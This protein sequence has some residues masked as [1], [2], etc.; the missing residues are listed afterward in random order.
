MTGARNLTPAP[1][2]LFYLTAG[3]LLGE[4]NGRG[5]IEV[6]CHEAN[7]NKKELAA[8]IL[9]SAFRGLEERGVVSLEIANKGFLFFKTTR[10][11]VEPLKREGASGLEGGILDALHSLADEGRDTE[12]E[13]VIYRWF[14]DGRHDPWQD[15]IDA[16]TR[17]AAELGLMVEVDPDDEDLSPFFIDDVEL[18]PDRRKIEA[19]SSRTSD[20]VSR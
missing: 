5:G 12:V 11:M 13:G 6:P 17:E 16:M 14:G 2:L 1:G 9:A 4:E 18:K 10:V 3:E 15:V 8:G 19:Q 7:V 20:F